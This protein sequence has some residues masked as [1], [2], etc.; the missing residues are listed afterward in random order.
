VLVIFLLA[1]FDEHV[2]KIIFE[3]RFDQA[4]NIRFTFEAVAFRHQLPTLSAS[5]QI[6]FL[7]WSALIP[8]MVAT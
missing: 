5:L 4:E 2:V 6:L 8:N 7:P 3:K 1:R